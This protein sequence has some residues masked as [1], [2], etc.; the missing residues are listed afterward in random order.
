MSVNYFMGQCISDTVGTGN[1]QLWNPWLTGRTLFVTKLIVAGALWSGTDPLGADI[2]RTRSPFPVLQSDHMSNKVFGGDMPKAELRYVTNTS[3]SDYPLNR[4]IQ[5][6]WLGTQFQD[7]TYTFDPPIEVPQGWGVAVS[8]TGNAK[9]IVSW[10]WSE[11]EMDPVAADPWLPI[12]AVVT[13]MSNGANAFDSNDITYASSGDTNGFFIGKTWDLPRTVTA[14]TL[15]SPTG[16]SLSGAAPPRNYTYYVEVFDGSVWSSA[17]SGTF[18]DP[19]STAQSVISA[20]GSW[21]GYGHRLRLS[22]S[23]IASHRVATL[24]FT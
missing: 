24:T 9:A 2:R 5:E 23:A 16:R 11:K 13:D 7:K 12:E 1:V 17:L 3:P 6:I 14:L 19:V 22:Q 10:Q 8:M 18:T 20:S 15:K 21:N 4:P